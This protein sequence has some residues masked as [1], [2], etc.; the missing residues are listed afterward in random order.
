MSIKSDRKRRFATNVMIVVATIWASAALG[1]GCGGSFDEE[2]QQAEGKALTPSPT[3][4]PSG[5]PSWD[6]CYTSDGYWAYTCPTSYVDGTLYV[7]KADEIIIPCASNGR[8]VTCSGGARGTDPSC[9]LATTARPSGCGPRCHQ[10]IEDLCPECDLAA[11]QCGVSPDFAAD[12]AAAALQKLVSGSS[13]L[14]FIKHAAMSYLQNCSLGLSYLNACA[15]C[16]GDAI[17]TCGP[18]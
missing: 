14:G 5:G 10:Y 13:W 3:F 11:D 16:I 1:L 17:A 4:N 15:N 8:G 2:D 9:S 7:C 18:T 12:T 6:A